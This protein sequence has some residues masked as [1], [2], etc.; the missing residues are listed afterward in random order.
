[1]GKATVTKRHDERSYEVESAHGTYR[2]NRVDLKQQPSPP[3]PTDQQLKENPAG[4][5]NKEQNP[6]GTSKTANHQQKEQ[7][8]T[9]PTVPVPER[10][11]RIRREPAYLK[12]Y[13]R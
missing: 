11:K 3:K 6:V 8:S 5:L 2:L 13:T 12:D 10:P 4:T 7:Q 1:M 9:P